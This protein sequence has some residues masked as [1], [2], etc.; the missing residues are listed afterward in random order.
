[1]EATARPPRMTEY[2][3]LEEAAAICAFHGW[4]VRDYGLLDSALA[5]PRTSLY[6]Q[7]MFPGVHLKGAAL[8]DSIN[9]HH[10]LIDGNKR[11]SWLAVA[12]FYRKNGLD[13]VAQLDDAE[14]YV[15]AI[16][17]EVPRLR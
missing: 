9:R 7:E 17:G 6:G 15:F 4:T 2:V 14:K 16:A 12:F 13:I 5:R 10:P 3:N 11:L 1:M 8:I